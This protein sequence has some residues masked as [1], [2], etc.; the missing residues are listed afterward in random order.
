MRVFLFVPN[1]M[2][3]RCFAPADLDRLRGSHELVLARSEEPADLLREWDQQ[4][5][6]ADAIILGWDTPPMTD[7][8]LDLAPRLRLLVHS[9]GSVKH[10][11]PPGFWQR[12]IRVVTCNDALAVGVAETTLGMMIAGL[13]GLFPANALTH[14]GGWKSDPFVLPGFPVRELFDVTIGLIGASKV[15][16]QVIRLLQAFE[17]SILVADPYLSREEAVRLGVKRV[18]LDELMRQ[19]DIVSL[20]APALPMT[21]HMLGGAQFG[22]MKD[23]AI[24]INTA[25]GSIVDEEALARELKTGRIFAFL[26]VTHPEPPASDHPFR[27]LP[28]VVLTPH[29]S[30][31]MS[32]GCRRMGRCAVDQLLLFAQGLRLPGEVTAEQMAILA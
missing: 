30:G 31:A 20:H 9:A 3:L 10:L 13:K 22:A 25:R 2:Q 6:L 32:N 14:A 7:A 17:V 19:S 12:R 11:L 27:N 24:F 18:S 15:G 28:N 8:M 21:R 1:S 16:R 29:I 26:D 23:H 5:P 4:A